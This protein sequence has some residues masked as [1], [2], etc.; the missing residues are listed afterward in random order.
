MHIV[1][2]FCSNNE[3][4]IHMVH[5]IFP[6][7]SPNISLNSFTTGKAYGP[8]VFL[9]GYLILA[10]PVPLIDVDLFKFSE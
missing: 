4:L 9:V 8:D 7:H 3:K 1:I 5:N 6:F 10:I 2:S